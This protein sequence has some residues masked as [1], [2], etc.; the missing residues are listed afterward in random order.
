MGVINNYIW[1]HYFWDNDRM[2]E[3]YDYIPS[4]MESAVSHIFGNRINAIII[5]L[6][7]MLDIYT[8]VL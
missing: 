5:S 8:L 4:E 1:I 6:I 7:T 2:I 3:K